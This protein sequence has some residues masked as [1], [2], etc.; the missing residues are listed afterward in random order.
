M[1]THHRLS[2]MCLVQDL[3]LEIKEMKKV[4]F[5][6]FGTKEQDSG[7]VGGH[8]HIRNTSSNAE[9]LT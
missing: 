8:E 9:D 2:H 1:A 7:G 5:Q 6:E 4:I 3:P